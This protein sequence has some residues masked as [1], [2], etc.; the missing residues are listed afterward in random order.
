MAQSV[1]TVASDI[2]QVWAAELLR[3]RDKL[4]SYAMGCNRQYES[5]ILR[6]GDTVRINTVGDITVNSSHVRTGADMT[7]QLLRTTSQSLV[8]DSEDDFL[9]Y[10]DDVDDVQA[11]SDLM[12][13]SM[14]RAAYKLRDTMDTYIAAAMAAGVSPDNTLAARTIGTGAGDDDAFD[15]LVD[16]GVELD[17]SDAPGENRFV[18]IPPWFSG[19]LL[20][21]PRRSSFGTTENLR[22]Y[23]SAYVGR[24]VGGLEIFVS[25][26]V[27]VSGSAYTVI[28]G[29]KD[30]TTLAEQINKYETN[31][32]PLAFGDIHKGLHVYG[33]KVLRPDEL[34]KC[35]VTA[36]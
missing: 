35:A 30:A 12:P 27:P 19:M 6:G 18:F 7:I 15:L 1:S 21:D 26:N 36:A 22:A 29:S 10:L 23:G 16:M 9:F 33:A 4:L 8:M 3:A 32:H 20:K 14:R 2:S 31:R 24:T 13:E 34:V 5:K 28:A 25:N 11:V 17:E